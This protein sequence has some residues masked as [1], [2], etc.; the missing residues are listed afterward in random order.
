MSE[1]QN[2]VLFVCYA[3]PP[4][5]GAGV[6]RSVK[7]TKY[8]SQF[9]WKP[10]VLTV[11]NPS[12]PVTDSDLA[13]DIDPA[14]KIVRARTLEPSYAVKGSL[15]SKG[16]PSRFSVKTFLRRTVMKLLQ[17]DPQ[18]LWNPLAYRMALQALSETPHDLI[19]VT[20]PPFSSFLL[21]QSLKRRTGL[22][23]VLDFRDEW[24]LAS[25]YM[26][27]HQRSGHAHSR[28][29]EMLQKVLRSAD[30]V[31]TTTKASKQELTKQ[32][33]QASSDASVSCIYNGYDEDDFASLKALVHDQKQMR[34]VYAGTLWKLTDATPMVKALLQL[35]E[36][37]PAA[38]A[39]IEWVIVGR[40][41]PEQDAALQ[42]LAASPIK[43]VMHDYV[44]HRQCLELA[45]SADVLL[46]LLADQ[47]GAERVVPAKLFEYLALRKRMLTV[48]GDGEV[49]T[50]AREYGQDSVFAPDQSA[51]IAEWLLR[52]HAAR[53]Q[54]PQ[55]TA[56]IE[57]FSRRALTGQLAEVFNRVCRS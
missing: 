41:T 42:P 32:V 6:Q 34:I 53:H 50:L 37:D 4:T 35:A 21:G 11:S 55:P 57:A 47:P 14:M 43:L 20:G 3:Y 1:R 51:A 36:R 25:R 38:A 5:G 13:S 28:H 29:K 39:K 19:F 12:V 23:L 9:G 33:S 46:L 24:L 48:C 8:L 31:M 45:A 54:D 30:A 49:S 22:P 56:S 52:Q 7:F 10:T 15:A 26:D 16:S 40:R 2:N 27:N 17:P 18:V 44:P